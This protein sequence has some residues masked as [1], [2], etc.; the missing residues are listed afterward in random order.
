MHGLFRL[1]RAAVVAGSTLLLAAAAH[2]ATGGTLP[3][4]LIFLGLLAL[5]ILPSV[6]LCGKRL[7]PAAVLGILGTGQFVL[8]TAFDTLSE[9]AATVPQF[10]PTAGHVHVLSTPAPFGLAAKG[11]HAH[12][13]SPVMLVA[14]IV[15]TLA[16]GLL[17]AKGEDALWALLGWLRPLVRLLLLPA[18]HPFPTVPAYAP[19]TLPRLWCSLRLPSRRGP[20]R[21]PATA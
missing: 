10:S 13:D 3:D 19:G 14:H 20:P 15:A 7:T 16:V 11:S 4:T 6:W 21:V 12:G 2:T 18:L 5:A 1:S 17:L 9:T 8:H